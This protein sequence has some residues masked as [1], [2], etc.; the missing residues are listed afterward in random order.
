MVFHVDSTRKSPLGQWSRC[1]V[2]PSR[3]PEEGLAPQQGLRLESRRKG[4]GEA[5]AWTSRRGCLWGS[6]LLALAWV[7]RF[8]CAGKGREAG[9]DPK[10]SVAQ[11]CLTVCDPQGLWRARLL[12]PWDSPGR[13][14]GG[15]SHSLLQGIFPTQ[16][17]NCRT[18]TEHLAVRRLCPKPCSHALSF[19]P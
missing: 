3:A 8:S 1:R 19:R 17:S 2:A 5:A 16:G 10:V 15:G 11:S 7:M 14:T 9:S 18:S 12:C 13:N 4:G 6:V